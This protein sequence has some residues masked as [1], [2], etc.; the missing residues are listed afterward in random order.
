MGQ[1]ICI[2]R[3]ST[4]PYELVAP[5]YSRQNSIIQIHKVAE[6]LGTCG[7]NG[8]LGATEAQGIMRN[9]REVEGQEVRG[10]P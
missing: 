8:K 4:G 1:R 6:D 3:F 2:G 10:R 5:E 9:K 7:E